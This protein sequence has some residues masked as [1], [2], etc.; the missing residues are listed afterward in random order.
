MQ[1]SD[2]KLHA[3]LLKAIEAA[4]H[5]TPTPVQAQAIPVALEGR[6]VLA[7]ADTGTGKTGAFLLPSLHR[8]ALA[9]DE[10]AA[11]VPRRAK[12]FGPRVLVLAP[13][14]E[15][16]RQ[17]TMAARNYVRNLRL[18]VVEVVGGVPYRQ[19]IRD[20]SR[21][22][23]VLVA[24]PGRL[25]DMIERRAVSLGEVEVLILDEADRM[26]DLGFAE[27]IDAIAKSCP[28][29]RQTL[30]FTATLDRRME[31]VARG[32]V[33]DPVRVA[34]ESTPQSAP[35]IE[36]RLVQAD[37]LAHKHRLLRHFV[38]S[39][40]VGK[41]I[42][43]AATKQDAADL[44]DGLRAE[45]H[46]AAALHGDMR[47]DARNRTLSKLREGRVRLL[48]ATDVAARGID[49]RD[50]THVINFDL[51]R[52]A[53]DYVHRIG[54]TG[55]AGAE[56]IAISFATRADRGTLRN[57]ERLQGATVPLH[58]VP[59]LEAKMPFT[60]PARGDRF[61]GGPR[62]GFGGHGGPGGFRHGGGGGGGF[63]Q[64]GGFGRSRDGAAGGEVR[65]ERPRPEGR[66][67]G[68]GFGRPRFEGPARDDAW[69]P[70]RQQPHRAPRH[71]DARGEDRPRA[72]FEGAAKPP[73]AKPAHAKPVRPTEGG[74]PR[75]RTPE[76]E[77]G[78]AP[79]KRRRF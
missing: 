7:T 58:V 9:E 4:G 21:P 30:L 6:D 35:K 32:L 68:T 15:L 40:E 61:G 65:G 49:V 10:A 45:G 64:G 28:D 11:A 51:P 55:R 62:R 50:I 16:A 23:D 74:A 14:R 44:A 41:A 63:R 22:V 13:T 31:N 43:F 78:M 48:V 26:L 70:E 8:L 60:A 25:I 37:D 17:V 71:A 34:I 36:Q 69:R 54:R 72:R 2:L 59:G 67:E 46:A 76:A 12:P 39:D 56:G 38:E 1:F 77:G 27:D 79:P 29:T 53:E 3:N 20:L 33:R 75:A 47:Q 18:F 5:T 66:G 73:H 57:I 19:Q 24:T 42:V 52:N